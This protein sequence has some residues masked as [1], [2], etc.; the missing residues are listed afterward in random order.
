MYNS[1]YPVNIKP[2]SGPRKGSINPDAE[3]NSSQQNNQNNQENKQNNRRASFLR[4]VPEDKPTQTDSYTKAPTQA[5]PPYTP[6]APAPATQNETYLKNDVNIAQI[7]IDFRNT[8]LAIG[9]PE[10]LGEEI[11]GYFNL[12]EKQA[13]KPEPNKKLIQSN[14][15][16]ASLLIDKFIT[17]SLGKNSRVVE[18]WIDTLF[19][20]K[21]NYKYDEKSVNPDF[22]IQFPERSQ[23][24]TEEDTKETEQPAEME[25]QPLMV[26]QKT[27]AAKTEYYIPQNKEL[28]KLFIQAKKYSM[29]DD[30][31]KALKSFQKALE[32]SIELGDTQAQS[33][34]FYE[35]GQIF[36]KKDLLP[37]AL[38]NYYK[39]SKKSS[40]Y[41]IKTKAHYNMAKIYDDFVKVEPAVEH[42]FV[43]ISYAGESENLSAQ[44]KSLANI[45]GMYAERYQ[46][47]KAKDFTALS[48]DIAKET[49]NPKVIGSAYAKGG[50]N[51]GAMG[52]VSEALQFYKESTK[53]YKKVSSPISV[54]RNLEKAAALMLELG[55]KHKARKLYREAYNHY[56]LAEDEE[57]MKYVFA[58][59]AKL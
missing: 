2:Y 53:Q 26:E 34:I 35:A 54:A 21:I 24:K 59:M 55:N 58:Q 52:E 43:A 3:G 51:Y 5:P 37:Q 38:K 22:Q 29:I 30:P 41:N 39:A 8:A 10:E 25:A 6:A 40:D 13:S 33:L 18:N 32:K 20:Q 17:E 14:L 57:S 9:V 23:Q 45:A 49:N 28:K 27:T 16:N 11:N 31:S 7:L 15:K 4:T 36:D 56:S 12:V 44:S 47:Q 1:I 46:K 48:T 42:Y 19:L 50:H